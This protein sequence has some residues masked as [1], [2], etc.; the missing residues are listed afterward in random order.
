MILAASTTKKGPAVKWLD[1]LCDGEGRPLLDLPAAPDGKESSVVQIRGPMDRVTKVAARHWLVGSGGDDPARLASAESHV[2]F[3]RPEST[4]TEGPVYWI[5]PSSAASDWP[6]LPVLKAGETTSIGHRLPL[7][8]SKG[9]SWDVVGDA[10]HAFLAADVAGMVA[11][12]RPELARRLLAASN[13]GGLL[14]PD[15]LV[16][17]GDQLRAWVESRWPGATWHRELPVTAGVRTTHGMR[18]V[19]GTIDLLIE[20]PEGVVIIDHKSFPG[21]ASQ[22]AA[23][24]EEFGPQLAAYAH[25]LRL[26]EKR[27]LGLF[28]HFTIGAG[29]V[30][31]HTAVGV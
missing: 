29:V 23:K 5:S 3:A 15:A 27:V 12:D 21:G 24:A 14:A 10:A 6:D 16:R 22:W 17:A 30:E 9:V 4:P 31:L 25:A 18:R 11:E 26:A 13:L 7:G 28:V 19:Q 1:E 2:W 20:T 8:D